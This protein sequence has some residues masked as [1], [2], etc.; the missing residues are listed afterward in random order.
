MVFV[1]PVSQ[2]EIKPTFALD[3]VVDIAHKLI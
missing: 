1:Q 2:I 3:V